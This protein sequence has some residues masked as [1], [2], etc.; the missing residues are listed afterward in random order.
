[1][2]EL[3]ESTRMPTF[4]ELHALLNHGFTLRDGAGLE[5]SAELIDVYRGIGMNVRYESYA[6]QFALPEGVSLPQAVYV[7]S[8]GGR[9]WPLLI[10]P[11]M[12]GEDGRDR[13]EAVFHLLKTT[14]GPKPA[15]A[16]E[17]GPAGSLVN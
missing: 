14:A 11:V 16:K 17:R 13:M 1:V 3:A 2:S 9:E 5:I 4:E 15:D 7:V 6:A 12:P 8:N 10:T